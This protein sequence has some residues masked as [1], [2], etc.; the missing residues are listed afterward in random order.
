MAAAIVPVKATATSKKR[1]ATLL[2][3]RERANLTI[4]MLT[5]VLKAIESSEVEQTVVIS[6]DVTIQKTAHTFNATYLPEKQPGLNVALEQATHWLT[7]KHVDSIL[8]L[9]SDIP[10]VSAEDI[11]KIIGLGFEEKSVVLSSSHDGGT[12]ALLKKPPDLMPV[13]FGTNSF[14]RHIKE[15]L[16]RNIKP[17]IYESPRIRM[18]IDSAEDLKD[19]FSMRSN[20]IS[21]RYLDSVDIGQRFV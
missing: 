19:F 15:A 2:S 21:Q 14:E 17:K 3:P 9:P 16:A 5:D 20:T 1:L 6:S 11:T 7:S 13:L 4:C 8:I 12:N 18:D 10:L